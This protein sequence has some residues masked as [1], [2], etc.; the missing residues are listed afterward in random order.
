MQKE[1]VALRSVMEQQS[2]QAETELQDWE[3]ERAELLERV[4]QLQMINTEQRRSCISAEEERLAIL[5]RE[6][7]RTDRE[8]KERMAR[9]R[10]LMAAEQAER[11]TERVQEYEA[12]LRR[13]VSFKLLFCILFRILYVGG[14]V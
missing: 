3:T 5:R 2:A 10:Q 7:I 14:C 4:L 8:C 13:L 1:S 6:K 12:K 11:W 9:E